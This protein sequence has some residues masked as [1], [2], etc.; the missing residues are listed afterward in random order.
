[1][2]IHGNHAQP[3]P[4]PWQLLVAENHSNTITAVVFPSDTS[5]RFATCSLDGTVRVW[6]L[7]DYRVL[8]KVRAPRERDVCVCVCVTERES[9]CV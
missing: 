8:C 4:S 9:V 7:S 2:H 6:D 3:P 5:D 1:M